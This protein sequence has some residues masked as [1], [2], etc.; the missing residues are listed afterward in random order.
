VSPWNASRVFLAIS[1]PI[2][3]VQSYLCQIVGAMFPF[4]SAAQNTF[5]QLTRKALEP[6][7]ETANE[8]CP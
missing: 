5:V 1:S 8:A 6:A 4:A 2:V 7:D 3:S